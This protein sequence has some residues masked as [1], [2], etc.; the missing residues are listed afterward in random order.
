MRPLAAHTPR[1]ILPM[2]GHPKGTVGDSCITDEPVSS[3]CSSD[4]IAGTCFSLDLGSQDRV[5]RCQV[6]PVDHLVK[7]VVQSLS[8]EIPAVGYYEL[9]MKLEVW[10]IFSPNS[11][12]TEK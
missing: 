2:A 1:S 5:L 6:W 8:R 3:F 12:F 11:F 4:S 10:G 9:L 7:D